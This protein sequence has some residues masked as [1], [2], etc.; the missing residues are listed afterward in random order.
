MDYIRSFPVFSDLLRDADHADVKSIE[1]D[2]SLPEF[3]SACLSYR[4]GWMRF[5]YWIR[6]G[7]ARFLGLRM[8][9][10]PPSER[11]PP[12]AISFTP[13][14]SVDFLTVTA[15]EKDAYW[16]GEASDKHLSGYLGVIAEALEDSRIRY[17]LLTVVHYRHWTGPVYFNII[18]PFHH[19]IVR[20]MAKYAAKA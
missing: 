6:S 20:A 5:L 15:S 4:P 13:G 3:L 18:R 12:E 9:S 7:L 17:R 2:K 16:V 11:M 19:I 14:D 1:S 8:T 10:V